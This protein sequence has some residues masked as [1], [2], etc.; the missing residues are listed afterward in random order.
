[1]KEIKD[2]TNGWIDRSIIYLYHVLG[3]EE[4]IL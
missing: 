2:N 4:S 1:M 3:L